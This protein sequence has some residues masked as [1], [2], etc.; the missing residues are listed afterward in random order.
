MKSFPAFAAFVLI[1]S[2]VFLGQGAA[3]SY[4]WCI[5]SDGHAAYEQA[6]D[7]RCATDIPTSEPAEGLSAAEDHCG[8][9]FDLPVGFSSAQGRSRHDQNSFVPLL[10]PV[11]P[12]LAGTPVV[13]P[14]LRTQA[15]PL[16]PQPPPG[17]T[18]FLRSLRT[19]VLLI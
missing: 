7:G 9:C 15:A 16:Q 18:A 13:S 14:Y 1:F 5:G 17:P 10:S 2:L 3:Q 11:G 6:T 4:V 19:I 8:P 12:A